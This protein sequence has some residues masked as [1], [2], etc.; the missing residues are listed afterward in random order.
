MEAVRNACLNVRDTRGI[1]LH[2]DLGSQYTSQVFENFLT[3]RG[4][5]HSFSC[6][7]N[8][9]KIIRYRFSDNI[10]ERLQKINWWDYDPNVLKGLNIAE[11]EQC[12]GELVKH[13][14]VE[15]K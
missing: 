9:A 12:L 3:S 10:I 4:M 5:V 13:A 8:P 15:R 14:C 6:K 2:S 11:P 1:I 7:G